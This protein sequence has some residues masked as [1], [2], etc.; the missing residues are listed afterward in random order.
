MEIGKVFFFAKYTLRSSASHTVC[1]CEL[2]FYAL[3]VSGVLMHRWVGG[4]GGGG[5]DSLQLKNRENVW[6]TYTIYI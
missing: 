4:D 5:R 3:Y 2:S 6:G 1:M